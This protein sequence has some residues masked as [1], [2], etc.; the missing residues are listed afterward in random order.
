[1]RHAAWLNAV[2]VVPG[3]KIAGAQAVSRLR[4]QAVLWAKPG[5]GSSAAG[6]DPAERKRD[7]DDFRPDMPPL[8]AEYLIGYLWEVGPAMETGEGS[9]PLSHG[10]LAA[11]QA[12]TGVV[13]EAWEAR[14]LRVL[15]R[16]YLVML[17]KAEKPEC[18]PPWGVHERRAM[19]AKKIDELFG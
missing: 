14:A 13:L 19:V 17:H 1:M 3:R 15:S 18:P 2:P 9:A 6:R 7:P 12:N 11:W 4:Q 10:E 5:R 8:E 16:E